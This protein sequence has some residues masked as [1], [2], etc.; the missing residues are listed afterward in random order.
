[1]KISLKKETSVDNISYE[2]VGEISSK[3][4][5]Y[6]SKDHYGIEPVCHIVASLKKDK[7]VI[8]QL[9]ATSLKVIEF[10]PNPMDNAAAYGCSDLIRAVMEIA[11]DLDD[12]YTKTVKAS[13]NE[14]DMSFV[15]QIVLIKSL[16]VKDRYWGCNFPK[17]LM[18][19]FLH[20]AVG[21]CS[22][23]AME[24]PKEEMEIQTMYWAETGF[25]PLMLSNYLVL[26]ALD[27]PWLTK[28]ETFKQPAKQM[29]PLRLVRD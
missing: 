26:L 25:K 8:S 2:E 11:S 15:N 6:P 22:L 7:Q 1:M 3:I 28:T 18:T 12:I 24:I 16:K 14:N 13:I 9:K 10:I 19:L 29:Q 27:H 23:V 21:S 5:V 20:N 17:E 4:S